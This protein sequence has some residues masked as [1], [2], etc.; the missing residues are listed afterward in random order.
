MKAMSFNLLISKHCA[1]CGVDSD[2]MVLLKNSYG[3]WACLPCNEWAFY[4]IIDD[5]RYFTPEDI[6]RIEAEDDR[7]WLRSGYVPE[8]AVSL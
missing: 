1:V 4:C 6:E 5:N 8:G 7:P 2:V 3:D